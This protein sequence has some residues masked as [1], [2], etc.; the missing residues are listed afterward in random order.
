SQRCN[1][2]ASIPEAARLE[3]GYRGF[4]I[5]NSWIQSWTQIQKYSAILAHAQVA[6]K[7]RVEEIDIKGLDPPGGVEGTTTIKLRA[8][9]TSG[10]RKCPFCKT[11][12]DSLHS[13]W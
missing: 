12:R 10:V 6:I 9:N 2:N 7:A 5:S 13:F 11:W 8:W 1:S 4:L 3:S